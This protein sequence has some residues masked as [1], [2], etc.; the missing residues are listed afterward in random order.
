MSA[1]G[2]CC[3]PLINDQISIVQTGKMQRGHELV[4][5]LNVKETWKDTICG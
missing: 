1:A 4:L 5:H 2:S 3:N